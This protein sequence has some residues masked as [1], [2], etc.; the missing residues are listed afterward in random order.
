MLCYVMGE[1]VRRR[2]TDHHH[3]AAVYVLLCSEGLQGSWLADVKVGAEGG[4]PKLDVSPL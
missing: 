1:C 4:Q 2:L 3:R